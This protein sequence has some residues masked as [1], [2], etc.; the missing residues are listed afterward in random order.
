[1]KLKYDDPLSNFAFNFNLRRYTTGFEAFVTDQE[2]G[3]E[4]FA[5][6]KVRRCKLTL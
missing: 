2:N 4:R 6:I 5:N 1:L 3:V